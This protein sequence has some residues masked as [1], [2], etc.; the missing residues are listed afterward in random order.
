MRPST[1]PRFVGWTFQSPVSPLERL[2][3]RHHRQV[4]EASGVVIC[5]PHVRD[6]QILVGEVTPYLDVLLSEKSHVWSRL[7]ECKRGEER[8][9]F[10][11]A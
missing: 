9:R 3:G 6:P 1:C 5:R 8:H 2:L 7:I 10:N 4:L 11:L